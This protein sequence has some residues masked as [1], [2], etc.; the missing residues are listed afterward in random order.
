MINNKGTFRISANNLDEDGFNNEVQTGFFFV[1]F[2]KYFLTSFASAV[3]SIEYRDYSFLFYKPFHHI[4]YCVTR[5]LI[6]L[7]YCL[8]FYFFNILFYIFN[9]IKK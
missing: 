8:Y 9:G 3:R 1:N 6:P 7:L 2:V 5:Q 4:F